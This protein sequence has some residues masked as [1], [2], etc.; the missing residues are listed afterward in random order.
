MLDLIFLTVSL[1]FFV[2]AVAYVHGCESLR[3]GSGNA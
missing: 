1:A 3:G 2:I